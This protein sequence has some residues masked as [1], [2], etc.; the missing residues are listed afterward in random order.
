MYLR[1]ECLV[2]GTVW[3]Y[4]DEKWSARTTA[5]ECQGGTCP[6][7]GCLGIISKMASNTNEDTR[8]IICPEKS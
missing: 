4:D 1:V 3:N 7:C 8:R 2:G 6:N 5:V